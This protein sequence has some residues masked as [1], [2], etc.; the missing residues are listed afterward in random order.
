MIGALIPLKPN[1]NPEMINESIPTIAKIIEIDNI[2][3]SYI[4]SGEFSN[5]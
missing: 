3:V 4:Y 2:E 1:T 5:V